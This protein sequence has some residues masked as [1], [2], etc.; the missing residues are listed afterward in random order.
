ML[1]NI[2]RLAV[3]YHRTFSQSS[4]R[5]SVK[6]DLPDEDVPP[7]FSVAMHRLWRQASGMIAGGCDYAAYVS[8]M[9]DEHAKIVKYTD[10]FMD[11]P[12]A[13]VIA[14]MLWKQTP[15]PTCDYAC[16]SLPEP[17]RN[18]PCP[19]G[20]GR[21]YKH[22]CLPL[23][24]AMSVPDI[25]GLVL[26]LDALPKKRWHELAG[27]RISVAMVEAAAFE[28]REKRDTRSAIALLEPWFKRDDAFITKRESLL[29]ALLDAYGDARHERKK[30]RLLERAIAAGDNV[31]RSA[32][33]QRQ[34][35]MLADQGD[36]AAAWQTFTQAQR[37]NPHA[38]SLSHLEV[39]ILLD[40]GRTDEARDRARFWIKRLEAMRD[41][42]LTHLIALLRD[43]G[44][45]GKA[46]LTD[47]MLEWNPDLAELDEAYQHAPSVASLYTLDPGDDETGPLR[48]KPALRKALQ[49][50]ARCSTSLA[51]SPMEALMSEEI[52][53]VGGI[54]D[55]LP[56]LREQPNLWNAFEVLDVIV[57]TLK[58]EHGE[59]FA[60][61]LARPLLD[62]AEQL[63]HEVL[64]NNHAEDKLFEWGWLENRPALNLLGERIAID[65]GR[66]ADA[67]QLARLEWLVF[68]LN[69]NDNQGF[70]D[71]LMRAYLQNARI[72][73]ALALSD[74][75]PDDFAN[76]RYNRAL[77][78]FAAGRRGEALTA[79][80]DAVEDSPKLLVWLLK[81]SPKPPRQ[82]KWGIRVGGDEE[83]WLYRQ[84]TLGLWERLGAMDW[85]RACAKELAPRRRQRP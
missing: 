62:R 81:T 34:A 50:W 37:A 55:W 60:Q 77:A 83:A 59:T 33:L 14:R 72:E 21:K 48:P 31:I 43:L 39:T 56:A 84:N 12:Q 71:V 79:L 85:V 9:R 24:H 66:P 29:D 17:E 42:N 45:R 8:A 36:Y 6:L 11:W 2:I 20:S 73:D 41:P 64:K 51:H 38:V 30:A 80:R 53:D 78:L 16:P 46:A 67:T 63:L 13:L 58:E 25:N 28:L 74:R 35:S 18:T 3:D 52:N 44:E 32:A 15:N 1:S 19:C 57:M 27:S 4:N 82:D 23:T 47:K 61:T 26:L 75:Y 70:R 7:E 22:C 68:T 69:P 5:I 76:M 40:E 54:E 10:G 65:V 49:A